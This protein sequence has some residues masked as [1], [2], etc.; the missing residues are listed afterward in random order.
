MQL[1]FRLA[2]HLQLKWY[3]QLRETSH[4]GQPFIDRRQRPLNLAAHS[5]AAAIK[6]LLKTRTVGNSLNDLCLNVYIRNAFDLKVI[7][8]G[9]SYRIYDRFWISHACCDQH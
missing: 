1:R 9:Q 5:V 7:F 4:A 8:E 2:S 6:H 3:K